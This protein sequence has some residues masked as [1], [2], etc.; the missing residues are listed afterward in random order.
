[1]ENKIFDKILDLRK[2]GL[3]WKDIAKNI[4]KEFSMEISGDIIRKRFDY[5]FIKQDDH[6]SIEKEVEKERFQ[7]EIRY[8]TKQNFLLKNKLLSQQEIFSLFAEEGFSGRTKVKLEINKLKLDNNLP[9]RDEIIVISDCHVGQLTVLD[10]I[11]INEYNWD[12]FQARLQRWADAIIKDTIDYSKGHN[13]KSLRFVFAGDLLE[14]H[15]VF[16]SQPYALDRLAME[17]TYY[18]TTAFEQAIIDIIATLY[19][20]LGYIDISFYCVAGNH[21]IP[22]G[23]KTGRS[24]LGL[25]YDYGFYLFL[26][27]CLDL[28]GVKYKTFAIPETNALLFESMKKIFCVVHGDE[29]RGWGGF[30]FYGLDKFDGK[31]IRYLDNIYKYI[32]LGHFHQQTMLPAGDGK[33]FVNGCWCGANDLTNQMRTATKPEQLVL[34]N[35]Q[36]YGVTHV[37]NILLLNEDDLDKYKFDVYN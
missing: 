13:I 14:G 23:R 27:H 9:N 6:K 1:M 17:Q 11:K 18:A 36:K 35:S 34:W 24:L 29:I 5:E 37:S 10:K 26:K 30:P 19:E 31:N 25:N 21:G 16:T 20:V 2:K 7:S 15:D 22:G 3:I 33:R 28:R 8:L 32:I 4:N 12:V